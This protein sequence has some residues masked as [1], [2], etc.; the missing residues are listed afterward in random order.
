MGQGKGPA[1]AR[2]SGFLSSHFITGSP[3]TLDQNRL[4]SDVQCEVNKQT[5]YSVKHLGGAQALVQLDSP[6]PTPE[7]QSPVA[8]AQPFP[9]L[10]H[11]SLSWTAW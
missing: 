8:S 2:D 6:L 11:S 3:S 9:P 1:W 5:A 10:Q 4:L 7:H